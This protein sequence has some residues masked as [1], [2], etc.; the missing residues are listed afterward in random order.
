MNE[1]NITFNTIKSRQ[2][3]ILRIV[4]PLKPRPTSTEPTPTE[5]TP[6]DNN[7]NDI[8][9][10]INDPELVTSDDN[11]NDNINNNYIINNQHINDIISNTNDYELLTLVHLFGGIDKVKMIL[12]TQHELQSLENDI[13]LLSI[14]NIILEIRNNLLLQIIKEFE[15]DYNDIDDG[16]NIDKLK[17]TNNN[18]NNNR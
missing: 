15:Q 10:N 7:N 17:S 3:E 5:A 6:N 16:I 4:P 2:E 18:S 11:N 9:N 12:K 13:I 8:I 14:D 1:A